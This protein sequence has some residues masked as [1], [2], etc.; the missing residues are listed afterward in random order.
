L[1]DN[2]PILITNGLTLIA[3]NSDKRIDEVVDALIE[4][5]FLTKYSDSE[6]PS[7]PLPKILIVLI[8]LP[9]FIM[10]SN[11]IMYSR[12]IILGFFIFVTLK[13]EITR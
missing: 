9:T 3:D 12:K 1:V 10:I 4:Y 8:R 2:N 13:L 11:S 6:N 7:Q 5:P